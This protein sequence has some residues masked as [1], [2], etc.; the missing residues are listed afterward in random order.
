MTVYLTVADLTEIIELCTG[1]KFDPQ[2]SDVGL[3]ASAV[4]RPCGSY[5]GEE[6]Y[7]T[8][9][10]KAAALFGSLALS[11]QAALHGNPGISWVALNVFLHLNGFHASFTDNEAY[12]MVREAAQRPIDVQE[13]AEHIAT[14][15][16][17]LKPSRQPSRRRVPA[18]AA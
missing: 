7:P 11:S 10:E 8:L 14:R 15:L 2:R 6:I 16:S 5:A 4:A 3:L 1:E 13:V 17:P 18:P 9:P 12:I